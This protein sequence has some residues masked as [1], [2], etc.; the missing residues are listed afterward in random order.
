[1]GATVSQ[2]YLFFNIAVLVSKTTGRLTFH[3]LLSCFFLLCSARSD[4]MKKK[5]KRIQNQ[6]LNVYNGAASVRTPH[7]LRLI[8]CIK[9]A[10]I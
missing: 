9:A 1:M 4:A 10:E 5:C 2:Q 7:E 6:L 8:V 3:L